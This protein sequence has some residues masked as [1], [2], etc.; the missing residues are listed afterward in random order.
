ML[1]YSK[2]LS[3]ELG[4]DNITINTICPGRID[5]GRLE[6][7]TRK[8][9]EQHVRI[10]EERQLAEALVPT[11]EAEMPQSLVE[12][13]LDRMLEAKFAGKTFPENG[14]GA[15]DLTVKRAQVA[16]SGDR[17]LI[18]LQVKARE[19]KSWFGLGGEATVF[20]WGKPVLDTAQ[21]ASN[22]ITAVELGLSGY[23]AFTMA[24]E[25]IINQVAKGLSEMA[26]GAPIRGVGSI[27]T[28]PAA[29]IT[30]NRSA[31][32]TDRSA[33]QAVT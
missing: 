28:A 18:A 3:H 33:S 10:D 11:V 29:P 25:G 7:V 17:L 14:S 9:A 32:R 21:R 23:H 26:G 4:P 27:V 22:A 2:T 13:E 16:A 8:R 24:N 1:G 15:V 31:S 6:L 20:V 30:S 5:T 19:T 12:H